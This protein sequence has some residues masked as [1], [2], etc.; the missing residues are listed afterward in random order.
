MSAPPPW[1]KGFEV[2][3]LREVAGVFRQEFRP[4][5][6]GAFGLPKERDVADARAA[7]QLMWTRL[8]GNAVAGAAIF[9]PVKTTTRHEDFAGRLATM[10]RGD[11]F[12]RSIA[13][14]REAKAKLIASARGAEPGATWVEGHVENAELVAQLGELGFRRVM[15]KVSA[16]SD[17]KGLWCDAGG[18]TELAR[19]SL[20]ESR[21]WPSGFSAADQRTVEEIKPRFFDPAPILAELEEHLRTSPGA[22][23]QHY[24]GYNKGRSWSAFALRGYDHDDPGFI[25][26]PSEMSRAWKEEHPERLAAACV[27][28]CAAPFFD[29]TWAALEPIPAAF[30]RVRFMRLAAA[31]GE[32]TRHADITDPEAGTKDGAIARLHMPLVSDPACLFRCW[33]LAGREDRMHMPVGSLC[34]LDTRK[35]HAVINPAASERIHL[36]ADAIM[37]PELRAW[38]LAAPVF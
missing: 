6:Y 17:L 29:A 34:Y 12:I 13:G 4:H 37:T 11:L 26:K 2:D 38:L 10:I 21:R 14:S 8:G 28:T 7:G 3:W 30:Q 18:V 15:T 19:P 25:I 32:L 1:A 5:T 36:V 16:S 31:G 9:R 23:A 33:S 24:S 20:A 22:F 35:P 27:P